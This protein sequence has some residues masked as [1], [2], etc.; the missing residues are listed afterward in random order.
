M[1]R[2]DNYT[3]D[4]GVSTSPKNATY[5]NIYIY[6]GDDL[7]QSV[8]EKSKNGFTDVNFDDTSKWY[9]DTDDNIPEIPQLPEEEEIEEEEI[10]VEE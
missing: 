5:R 2:F 4:Y 6:E 3:N 9:E 10:K 7:I 1:T 8:I